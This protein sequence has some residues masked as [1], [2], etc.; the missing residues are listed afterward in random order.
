M[1]IVIEISQEVYEHA[2]NNS[3]DSTDEYNSMRAISNGTPLPKGHGRLIDADGVKP[4]KAPIAPLMP[5][6]SV[7]YEWVYMKSRIDNAPTIIEAD[8][9]ES[10]DTEDVAALSE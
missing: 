5:E 9:A 10:E 2:K 3:E 4:I 8:K 6:D 1:K 7:H